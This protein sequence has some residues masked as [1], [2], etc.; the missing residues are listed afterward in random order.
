MFIILQFI[1]INNNNYK[2]TCDERLL[3]LEYFR[4]IELRY[5]KRSILIFN[6]HKKYFFSE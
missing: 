5:K 2:K 6:T 3:L 4:Y 1:T